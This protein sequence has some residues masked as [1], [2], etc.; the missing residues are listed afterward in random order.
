[1]SY[2]VGCAFSLDEMMMN[3]KKQKLKSIKKQNK[4]LVKRIAKD[5]IKLVLNDIIENN[6]T[7]Q[8]PTGSRKSDIHMTRISG[9]DFVTATQ[10]G[11]FQDVDYLASNFSGY[12]LTLNMYDKDGR[13]TRSKPIYL[14]KEFKNRITEYTNQGKQYQ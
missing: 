14:N 13:P 11:K 9:D 1:M 5:A 12:Q 10:N 2:A 8:L 6:V 3:F 7:F 4:A